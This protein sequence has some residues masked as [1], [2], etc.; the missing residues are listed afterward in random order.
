MRFTH[1]ILV[2]LLSIY[3]S[4]CREVEAPVSDLGMDYQPLEVGLFW[5]YEVNETLVFG[6]N[7]A[8]ESSFLI[9]DKVDYIY[10]NAEG[11]E[12]FVIKREK[13]SSENFWQAVY[14]YPM[15]YKN[16][17]LLK[18]IENKPTVSLIFPPTQGRTWD[19]AIYSSTSNDSFE[20]LEIGSLT[21]GEQNFNPALKVLQEE[22]DDEITFRDNRYEVYAL[23]IGLVEHYFEVFTYCSR[24]DCL[25]DK[26]IDSGR[27]THMRIIEYGKN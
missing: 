23:G 26:L 12:V 17:S 6:E 8:E 22:A 19:G 10:T 9:R 13:L 3:L 2:F 7:D 25:G 14:N 15:Q 20:I 24:N 18:T 21:I 4:A 27:K 5:V 16:N 1:F 11:E